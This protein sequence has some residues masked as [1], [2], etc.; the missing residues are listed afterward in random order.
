MRTVW[1]NV[2]FFERLVARYA[3]SKYAV[4]VD[5]C[6]NALFLSMMYKRQKIDG[7]SAIEV[8]DIPKRTY[9]SVPMMAIHCGYRINFTDEKWKGTYRLGP[10]NIT[11]GAQRFTHGM[12]ESKTLHCLSFHSKKTLSIGR[13]GMILTDCSSACSWLKAARY[14]GRPSIY[15]N[16]LAEKIPPKCIGWH[17]YMTPDE[18]A[19]GIEQFYKLSNSNPD[20]GKSSDY[21][22]DLS[23]LK[24]FE[25]YLEKEGEIQQ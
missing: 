10:L 1:D 23:K 15:Y 22:V 18:A 13:G 2:S 21:K 20:S 5:S 25:P 4:A 12:Y 8:I 19:R 3:G 14:D 9:I 24:V 16:D 7:H 17:M 11:D 6:S